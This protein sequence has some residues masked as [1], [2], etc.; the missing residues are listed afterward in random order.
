[1]TTE[2]GDARYL[3]LLDELRALHLRKAADYGTDA[4]PLANLRASAELGI[5]PWVGCMLRLR[6]KWSRVQAFVK[7]GKLTNEPI[8]DNLADMAAYCLLALR[9]YREDKERAGLATAGE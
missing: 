6:D 3:A 5:P 4:D 1:M 7:K 2:H 9:L 8:D